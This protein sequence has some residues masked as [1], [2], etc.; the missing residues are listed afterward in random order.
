[1]V[2]TGA[3]ETRQLWDWPFS[4]SNLTA[5]LRRLT[6]DT[7]LQVQRVRSA[8]M[9][10]R[11]PAIGRLY[12]LDVDYAGKSGEGTCSLVVKEP[13]GTTRSGLAGAGRREVGVY[14][15]LAPL[16]PL[17][18]P[19]MIAASPTG[20]WLLLEALYE[21]RD[22]ASWTAED[23]WAAVDGLAD[24]HDR[25]WGLGAD[26]EAFAWL[27]RP[28]D[29]DFEV[30]VTAA[31]KAIERIVRL[32]GEEPLGGAPERVQVLARLTTE[33][34]EVVAPLR[35]QP[36][37]L[38][39]GDYWPGNIAVLEQGEQVV[40]DWQLA[41]VG[42]A[43]IDLLVFVT[44]SEWWFGDLPVGRENLI[45]RYR[46]DMQSRTGISWTEATWLEL[47]DHALMWRFLQEWLDLL[48]ATPGP[49]LVARAD[50]LD[51]IWLDPVT[52]AVA[53]RLGEP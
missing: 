6:G 7:S 22:A 41:S 17:R 19:A 13:R 51:R 28:I 31:A 9:P 3:A 29:A 15:S 30:H 34:E 8:R 18:T 23:Y 52:Q 33:A 50:Q 36:N 37:T 35:G 11:R 16:L 46:E 20:D 38:L 53:R 43:V 4:K 21:I 14:Q 45:S 44:K 26:L 5:G 48:A 40:Y 42:P 49:L 10:H 47:W 2:T 24:L 1:M 25:Y 27:G 12:A 32:G 39:H